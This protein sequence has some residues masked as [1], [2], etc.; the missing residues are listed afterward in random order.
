IVQVGRQ[1]FPVLPAGTVIGTWTQRTHLGAEPKSARQLVQKIHAIQF[2]VK[3]MDAWS[4]ALQAPYR[5][6]LIAFLIFVDM[7]PETRLETFHGPVVGRPQTPDFH[8]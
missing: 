5:Q 2:P 3:D 8:S 6:A 1:P 4:V 7:K